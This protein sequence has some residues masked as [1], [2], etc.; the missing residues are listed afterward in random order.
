MLTLRHL[1]PFIKMT[2]T[3]ITKTVLAPDPPSPVL[4]RRDDPDAGPA[5]SRPVL[6]PTDGPDPCPDASRPVLGPDTWS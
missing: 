3:P 6:S 5:L 1:Q 2:L 4:L